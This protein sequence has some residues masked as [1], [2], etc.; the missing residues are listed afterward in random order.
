MKS[1]EEIL[2]N[3]SQNESLVQASGARTVVDVQ[4]NVIFK[5]SCETQKTVLCLPPLTALDRDTI[6][7]RKRKRE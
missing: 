7:T 6:K 2:S 5:Q 3:F 4:V 1:V